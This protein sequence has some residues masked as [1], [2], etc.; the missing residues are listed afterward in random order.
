MIHL[1]GTKSQ[2]AVAEDLQIPVST[3]AMIESGHRFPRRQLQMKLAAYFCV[4]VDELFFSSNDHEMWSN[5]I[6]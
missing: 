1:R 4:T 6:S 2:K 3:Y 5:K